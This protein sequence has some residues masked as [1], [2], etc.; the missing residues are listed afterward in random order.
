MTLA[1]HDI[2]F[3]GE[4]EGARRLTPSPLQRGFSQP[5]VSA[6][7]SLKGGHADQ[8]RALEWADVCAHGGST[9]PK[10][11]SL[12]ANA[13]RNSHCAPTVIDFQAT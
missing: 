8:R 1:D 4:R 7:G 10:R 3:G 9:E 12:R 2:E 5:S 13:S 6:S 11:L